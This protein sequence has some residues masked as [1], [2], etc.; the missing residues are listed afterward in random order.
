MHGDPIDMINI[1][2]EVITTGRYFQ[3]NMYQGIMPHFTVI[4][5]IIQQY[6]PIMISEHLD[7]IVSHGFRARRDSLR[8]NHSPTYNGHILRSTWWARP[9]YPPR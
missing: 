2:F 5:A 3:W 7:I 1:I 6:S 8:T 4:H 9:K